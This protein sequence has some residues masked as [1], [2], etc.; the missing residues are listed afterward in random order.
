MAQKIREIGK[1]AGALGI[2]RNEIELSGSFKAKIDLS[3]LDRLRVR[4]LSRYILVSAITPTPF[5]E[6]KTVTTIGLSM[7]LNRLKLKAACSLRQSSLGPLFGA[8][9]MATGGGASQLLP[10]DEINLHF[11]GT[12]MRQAWRT[13]CSYLSLRTM[14]FTAIT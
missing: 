7:A 8:K 13:I 5:G 2:R 11:T 1:I 14:S 4:R 9:G 6:G 10:A 3:I 12:R